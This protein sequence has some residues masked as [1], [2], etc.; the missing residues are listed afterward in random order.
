MITTRV[1]GIDGFRTRAVV[2]FIAVVC[3][4]VSSG[5]AKP[6]VLGANR[7]RIAETTPDA[8]AEQS[9][10]ERILRNYGNLALSFE[11]NRGQAD[12]KVRFLSRGS[13]Y[14]LSLTDAEA[15]LSLSPPG[16]SARNGG[17]EKPLSN[18]LIGLKLL[19]ANDAPGVTGEDALPG[20]VNYLVGS[21]RT[22]WSKNVPTY[23]KVRYAGVYP[24]VDLVYYGNQSQLEYDFVVAPGAETRQI[25]LH[26]DGAQRVTLDRD[27]DLTLRANH[28]AIE[29]RKPTIYQEI[30]GRRKVVRGSFTLVAGNTV[31]FKLAAYDHS[32]PLVIDPVLAYSTYYGYGD[33][34]LLTQAMGVAVD[35]SGCAYV[36]AEGQSVST[37][38]KFNFFGS[39]IVYATNLG[40]GAG[41]LGPNILAN[42]IAADAKGDAFITGLS[43]PGQLATTPGAY[44]PT[45][46]GQ[47][48]I[49]VSELSPDGSDFLYSTFLAPPGNNPSGIAVDGSGNIYVT[50]GVS[51][52]GFP[53]TPGAYPATSNSGAFL[54][55]INPAGH[56]SSDLVY[57]TYLNAASGTGIAPDSQGNIFITGT[58]EPGLPTTQGAF[59]AEDLNTAGTFFYYQETAFMAKFKPAGQ[60][61]SDLVY[62]TYLG[63]NAG[64]V[65]A[66]IAVDS[67]G[68]A[69]IAGSTLSDDFPVTPG[70]F[71]T[72]AKSSGSGFISKIS[73]QGQ[74]ANDL[75]Y[76][77]YLGGSVG[78]GVSGIALDPSGNVIVAG[79]TESPDFP[80]TS[81]AFQPTIDG[82]TAAAFLTQMSLAGSGAHDLLYSTFLSGSAQC[83]DLNTSILAYGLAVDTSGNAYLVGQA[84]TP[85][86][87]TTPEAYEPVLETG[88]ILDG[89]PGVY[90]VGF[91]S[92]FRF[93]YVAPPPSLIEIL[94]GNDQAGQ[95]GVVLAEPLV[96]V[97]KDSEGNP[98]PS[99]AVSFSGAN[100]QLNTPATVTN[101]TGQAQ[102]TAI[103]TAPCSGTV[104]ASV[105]GLLTPATFNFSSLG[106]QELTISAH[107][108]TT[109]YGENWSPIFT[110]A[111]GSRLNQHYSLK[112]MDAATVSSPPPD[113]LHAGEQSYTVVAQSALGACGTPYFTG[114]SNMAALDILPTHI[115][116]LALDAVMTYGGALP[117]FSYSTVNPAING[118]ALP[119]GTLSGSPEF[120]T[121]ATSA[122]PVG[123][124]PLNIAAGSLAISGPTA[125]DYEFLPIVGALRVERAPLTVTPV[126]ISIKAGTPIPPL[127]D[128]ITGFVNSDPATVVSGNPGLWTQTNAS[129][130]V[131]TY[132][133]YSNRGTL[134]AAN[135]GFVYA[136]G[137]LTVTP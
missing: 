3:L 27:G 19:G 56:G 123:V 42:A 55:K 135:Y 93:H 87:P 63:G 62:S 24:G 47:G 120:S 48:A 76:S 5:T 68:N 112:V 113:P 107:G 36:I 115:K 9:A 74:G 32:R 134:E 57:S 91:V 106:S 20:R 104:T 16:K 23:A 31:G 86:F 125:I 78:A 40:A 72:V 8:Q 122:S 84:N 94:S 109:T 2:P 28:G 64:E 110:V 97:V 46:T 50:G 133:I 126:S 136:A 90:G 69:Y 71:Q 38:T 14:S 79:V 37:V 117:S 119:P 49:F 51:A 85:N 21:D 7:T 70:A 18:D 96:V 75:L 103:P 41:Y 137:T 95:F 121:T 67:A 29:F 132:T 65:S 34:W 101:A 1:C 25:R 10:R 66:G 11:I 81:D 102:V 12:S 15:F 52:D 118:T 60:G 82:V 99:V 80:V 59:Q 128:K 83:C 4:L 88:G 108:V 89:G 77:T 22:K 114:T 53:V 98:V 129:P 26:F 45:T 54:A 6:E 116:L 35:P 124:Y 39:A 44:L 111:S 100:I 73:P 33:Y 92:K 17:I 130:P 43:G 58:A 30:D 13:G 105:G 131:G 127:T 61:L